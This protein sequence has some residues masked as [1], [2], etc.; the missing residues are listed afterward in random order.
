[1]LKTLLTST[2]HKFSH[3]KY[4]WSLECGAKVFYE[5]DMLEAPADVWD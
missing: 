5:V 4:V 2:V 3:N 1:M